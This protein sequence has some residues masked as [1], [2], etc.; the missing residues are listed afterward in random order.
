MKSLFEKMRDNRVKR[1][2]VTAV[3]EAKL[4]A[5]RFERRLRE[6]NKWFAEQDKRVNEKIS[7]KDAAWDGFGFSAAYRG[8][9]GGP[10]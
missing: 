1:G 7:K 5:A 3:V 2:R 10:V 6:D 4:D 8:D 9:A